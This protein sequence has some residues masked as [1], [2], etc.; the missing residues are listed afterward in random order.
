MLKISAKDACD[1]GY[2]YLMF[3]FANIAVNLII[4]CLDP[5]RH[6]PHVRVVFTFVSIAQAWLRTFPSSLDQFLTVD[7]S[8]KSLSIWKTCRHSSTESNPSSKTV[9]L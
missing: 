3:I 8:A 5:L 1:H 6:Y 4:H 9:A 7:Q 2:L